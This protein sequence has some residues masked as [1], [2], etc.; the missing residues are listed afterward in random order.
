[1]EYE[2]GP[3]KKIKMKPISIERAISEDHLVLTEITMKAKAYWQYSEE[4]LAQWA[5]VLTVSKEYISEKETYKLLIENNIIAGYYSYFIQDE[6]V[7]SLDNLFI[8]PDYIGKGYGKL[9][10]HD[11]FERISHTGLGKVVLDSEPHA[12]RFYEKLGFRIVGQFESS[13][14]GRFLPVMEIDLNQAIIPFRY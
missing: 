1:M 11:F 2:N 12:V 4:Q 14:R 10:M 3:F 5:D 8:M 7:V 13:I 9:L 6:Q